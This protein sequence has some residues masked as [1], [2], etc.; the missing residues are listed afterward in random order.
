[1]AIIKLLFYGNVISTNDDGERQS[2]FL[3]FSGEMINDC[4]AIFFIVLQLQ[5]ENTNIFQTMQ[6]Q[7]DKLLELNGITFIQ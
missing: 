3:E 6:M 1:M 2:H 4:F 5:K 7:L